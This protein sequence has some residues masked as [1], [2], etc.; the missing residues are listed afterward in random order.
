MTDGDKAKYQELADKINNQDSVEDA[1]EDV[2]P[3]E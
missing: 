2:P 1:V 3:S